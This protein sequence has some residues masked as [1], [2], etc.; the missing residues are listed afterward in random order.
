M[1]ENLSTIIELITNIFQ[2]VVIVTFCYK[3]L[4]PKYSKLL[5][6]VFYFMSISTMF[7]AVTLINGLFPAFQT[8]EIIIYLIIMLSYCIF[9]FKDRLF[10]RFF[11]PVI[12]VI[13]QLSVTLFFHFLMTVVLK[14]DP[15]YLMSENSRYRLLSLSIIN[16]SY[17]FVLY[18]IYKIYKHKIKLKGF[19]DVFAFLVLPVVTL[20]IVVLTF[21]ISSEKHISDTAILYLMIIVGCSLLVAVVILELLVRISKSNDLETENKIMHIKSE[22]YQQ[23]IDSNSNYIKEISSIKHDMKNKLMCI[24]DLITDK[25]YE[26]A[27]LLCRE[28]NQ[29][30]M[31]ASCI[32]NTDNIFLNSILN[33]IYSKAKEKNI[34]IKIII[35]SD[36]MMVN[37]TDLISLIGNLADNAITASANSAD[38]CIVVSITEKG[39]YYRLIIK[40]SIDVSVLKDNPSLATRKENKQKH[41]YGLYNI[42][43]IVNKYNGEIIITEDDNSFIVNIMLRQPNT[44]KK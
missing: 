3:L 36:F 4:T 39:E 23:Q 33:V 14:A 32:F 42:R 41:G 31:N 21:A 30:L 24:D 19:K 44:T 37:G 29:E 27:S 8:F 15:D 12:G 35:K 7:I 25:K 11:A 9:F 10:N 22:M 13:V 1:N 26:E 34:D 18:I 20:G 6:V 40:N 16:F 43:K 28:S 38:K 2:G 17:T 5:N